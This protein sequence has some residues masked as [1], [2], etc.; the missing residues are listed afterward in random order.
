M[1]LYK[2]NSNGHELD[3]EKW[4]EVVENYGA[5][6][7][8]FIDAQLIVN[9]L[10]ITGTK[11]ST[12]NSCLNL[13]TLQKPRPQHSTTEFQVYQSVLINNMLR[14]VRRTIADTSA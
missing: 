8:G 9:A 12:G 5:F 14:M 6:E 3:T 13:Q 7:D 11:R 10:M 2:K 4:A 1:A